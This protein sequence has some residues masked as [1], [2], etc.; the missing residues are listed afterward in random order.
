MPRLHNLIID[1][2]GVGW[3]V[4]NLGRVKFD[5][6]DDLYV[7]DLEDGWAYLWPLV[8]QKISPT[9]GLAV[10]NLSMGSARLL[11]GNA[12]A[13]LAALPEMSP[14]PH[15]GPDV[16][17]AGAEA[18]APSDPPA[19]SGGPRSEVGG[20]ALLGLACTSD[21]L[22]KGLLQFSID[23]TM[24][25]AADWRPTAAEESLE[26][27]LRP[28][29]T[30]E[31]SINNL[32]LGFDPLFDVYD[33]H[34][35]L[36]ERCESAF[37]AK[38]IALAN[39]VKAGL[40]RLESLRFDRISDLGGSR[41]SAG[42]L[43]AKAWAHHTSEKTFVWGP[44]MAYYA[45]KGWMFRFDECRTQSPRAEGEHLVKPLRSL[46]VA[47]AAAFRFD[48]CCTQ[49]PRAE[50]EHLGKPLRSL[51]VVR[52]SSSLSPSSSVVVIAVTTVVAVGVVVIVVVVVI[53]IVV[54]VIVV[55]VI[56]VVTIDATTILVV[57]M[58]V[59]GV[60]PEGCQSP[61]PWSLVLGR[62]GRRLGVEDLGTD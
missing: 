37:T 43:V 7:P 9:H 28:P 42:I 36:Y 49:S 53:V 14:D 39:G 35:Q 30:T 57:I 55:V 20:P 8:P 47:I 26:R 29:L 24:W 33:R 41:V 13:A 15:E 56:V 21:L 59:V 40:E 23:Y 46:V 50:G 16:F 4:R 62:V 25:E 1:V 12:P 11:Q 18:A 10:V 27:G 3:T 61:P 2:V 19:S 38:H 31:H 44:M 54:V 52:R 5:V 51:V 34:S 45:V 48:E 17:W 6:C 60:A 32:C 22:D 58:F